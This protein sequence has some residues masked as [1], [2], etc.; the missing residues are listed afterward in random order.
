MIFHGNISPSKSTN[1]TACKRH[2]PSC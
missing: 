2:F 1:E